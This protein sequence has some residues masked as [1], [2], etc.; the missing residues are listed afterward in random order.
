MTTC[1]CNP[2]KNFDQCCGPYLAGK[3]NAPTAEALMRSR[4]S[5]FSRKEYDYIISTTHASTRPGEKKFDQQGEPAWSGLEIISTEKGGPGD[6]E[7]TVEF[8]ARYKSSGGTYRYHEL[9]SFVF[10]DGQWYYVDGD[11][12][13]QQTVRSEKIGRNQ[14]CPCGSGRKYKKCCFKK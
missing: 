3:T 5:A 7:G 11:I 4:Y 6:T 13:P 8:I 2:E 1:P 9:S 12:I 10:E 14:P